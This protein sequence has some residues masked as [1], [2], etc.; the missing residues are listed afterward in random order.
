M[1]ES[2]FRMS[3]KQ[4][5]K[6]SVTVQFIEEGERLQKKPITKNFNVLSTDVSRLSIHRRESWIYKRM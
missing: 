6:E 2:T 3:R 5:E 4:M 1:I